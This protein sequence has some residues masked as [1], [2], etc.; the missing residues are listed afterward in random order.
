MPETVTTLVLLLTCAIAWWAAGRSTFYVDVDPTAANRTTRRVIW[1]LGGTLSAL[2]V[3]WT[4][5]PVP[6]TADATHITL[7]T[8]WMLSL[9][10]LFILW[11]ALAGAISFAISSTF[12]GRIIRLPKNAAVPTLPDQAIMA[13]SARAAEAAA[14]LNP[15][16]EP[17]CFAV[18][19]LISVLAHVA[20]ESRTVTLDEE[21]L[22]VSGFLPG[23][24]RMI[25]RE[26]IQS[27][28]L[29]SPQSRKRRTLHWEISEGEPLILSAEDMWK[30][31]DET[32]EQLSRIH[33]RLGIPQR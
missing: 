15:R 30:F 9:V 8:D 14:L 7:H 20:I 22:R 2:L 17:Y 27:F 3:Y 16:V 21:G 32:L 19:G 10:P 25:P 28:H 13:G 26:D 12:L 6:G 11:L 4:V 18:F 29:Q 23:V 31:G 5:Q 24:S 33:E 1:A